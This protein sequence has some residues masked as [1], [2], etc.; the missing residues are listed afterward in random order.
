M[1]YIK[2]MRKSF[3]LICIFVMGSIVIAQ[4][5]T[6]VPYLLN[7]AAEKEAEYYKNRAEVEEY[8]R[9][10]N[11]QIRQELPDG[12]IIE[13][14]RIENGRPIYYMTHNLGA[15][16]TTRANKLWPSGGLGLNLTG[17]GYNK[18]G[19]WDGGGVLLTHQEF[20]SR[21]T[22][23][24][25]PITSHYH[26]T[27]VAG[28][29]IAAGVD[30]NAKGMAPQ[31][32]LAAYDWTMD[33]VE[34]ALA[35]AGGMEESNHSYGYTTGWNGEYWYGDLS[36]STVEDHRFGLYSAYPAVW[37]DIAY[38][39]PYYL[40]V[41]SAG[42][43]RNDVDGPVAYHWH[44]EY[45]VPPDVPSPAW[46][47]VKRYDSH[48]HGP[49]GGTYGYDC[50]STNGVA[51]NVLSVGAVYEVPNYSVP[52][53][54]AMSTFSSWGPTDDGRIKPD[55]VG[56]GV[57]VYSTDDDNNS[58]YTILSGTSMSAPNV[59]GTCALLQQHYQNTH[60]S[61]P[62]RSATL[63]GLVIHTADEAGP[64]NGPDYMNGWGLMNA[65][66][67][68][69]LISLDNGNNEI[70]EQVL[71]NGGTYTRS[72]YSDG[73]N[74]LRVT[75]CW[76][77][78]KGTPVSSNYL[79]NRTP[80]LVNDL[81][82][83]L[84]RN[85][86]PYYPWKLDPINPSNAATNSGKNN[87]DNVEQVYI[88]SPAAGTYTIEV[89]HDG[90]LLVDDE[91]QSV[92]SQAFSIIMSG[93][94][95]AV[96]GP[97]INLKQGTTDIA[98]GGN[99]NYGSKTTGTDTDIVFTIENTGTT[100]N[101]TLTIPLTISGTNANQFSIQAQPSTPVSASG[102]TTFTARFS[103]TSAGSKTASI[104]IGNNDSDENPYNLTLTGTGAVPDPCING[105]IIYNTETGKFNFCEN[106]VWVEK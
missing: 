50:I 79:N 14:M 36:I 33:E 20:G 85:T 11:V 16:K 57:S 86:T 95:T 99:Y 66:R 56:K 42:N 43:D 31:A 105:S 26:A 2:I 29:M 44:L 12:T 93:A 51:K 91:T 27:H 9:Q 47:W 32:N 65:E 53:D 103:P 22:Q 30:P 39:A 6:N 98:D 17:S 54:V 70:D 49:D 97:E 62:M 90:T 4:T 63:K 59:T 5:V 61:T 55:I 96:P 78:P 19:E 7:F 80:M 28:T 82:L 38:N 71:S 72:I 60:S 77:D 106:G 1:H 45:L 48:T 25:G 68:A 87:V 84:T 23:I 21:V 40:I 89:S 88:A 13:M 75:I 74:P 73:T 76:T 35:A 83:K 102:N 8:A 52:G 64:S 24:D 104:A 18:L 94:V 81:D 41:K 58:D 67:A 34:M 69:G 10:A 37:D 3:V 92:G 15:A 100:N 46:Y 101:L